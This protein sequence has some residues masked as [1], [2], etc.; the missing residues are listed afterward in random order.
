MLDQERFMEALAG[1]VDYAQATGGVLSKQEIEGSLEG[2]DLSEKQKEMVY[3]YL[4]EKKIRVQGMLM[5][6]TGEGA[7]KEHN[8]E[9]EREAG[10]EPERAQRAR[11]GQQAAKEAGEDTGED[12]R[13]LQMYLEELDGLARVTEGER[14]ALAMRLLAGEEEAF[15]GLLDATLYEVVDIAKSY[16][17]RGVYLEDLIQEGNIALMQVLKEMT[18]RKKQEEPLAYIREYVRYAIASYIDEQSAGEDEEARIVAKLGLLHEAA[19]Y[20]AK[21]NGVLPSAEELADYTKLPVEEIE[22]LARLSKDVDFLGSG[23]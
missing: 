19:K 12:S 14:L 2:M 5:P 16:R 18:G 10:E 3:G 9:E 17:G 20:M 8:E 6:E 7:Q 23:R 1:L 4:L 15:S 11:Q 21:E 13:Y 22:E